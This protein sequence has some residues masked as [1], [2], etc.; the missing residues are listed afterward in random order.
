MKEFAVEV[1]EVE[2][3]QLNR[4]FENNRLDDKTLEPLVKSLMEHGQQVP[5]TVVGGPTGPWTLVNGTRRFEALGRCEKDTILVE[6]WDCDVAT[7]LLRVLARESNRKREPLEEAGLIQELIGRGKTKAQL[8]AVDQGLLLQVVD[9]I[10]IPVQP[11]KIL[12]KSRFF[13]L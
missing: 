9:G 7:G 6:I 10:H 3:H 5:V 1:R 2:R 8:Y 4:P 12:A 11:L 13:L